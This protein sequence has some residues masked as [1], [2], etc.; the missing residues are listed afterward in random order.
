MELIEQFKN[1]LVNISENPE[2]GITT[3]DIRISMSRKGTKVFIDDSTRST[4]QKKPF[5]TMAEAFK[6]ALE[7]FS[8]NIDYRF[9]SNIEYLKTANELQKPRYERQNIRLIE[10]KKVTEKYL[11]IIN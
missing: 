5:P 9:N 11:N 10:V 8:E 4:A 6:N 7:T 1:E 3:V 2:H